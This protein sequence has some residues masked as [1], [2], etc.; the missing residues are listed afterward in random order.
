MNTGRWYPKSKSK[1]QDGDH[2]VAVVVKTNGSGIYFD[3]FGSPPVHRDIL[4]FLAKHCPRGYKYNT[5]HL[6]DPLSSACGLYCIDFV[7]RHIQGVT[8]RDYLKDFSGDCVAND[9]L[10]LERVS[11]LSSTSPRA[12]R[13][14]LKTLLN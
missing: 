4:E 3:S 1:V 7:A 6:Q 14:R 2:W 12:S 11:C 9:N 8:L 10:V 13:L 5:H